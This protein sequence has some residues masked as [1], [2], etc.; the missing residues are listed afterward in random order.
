MHKQVC[1]LPGLIAG[2]VFFGEIM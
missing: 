1:Y 2:E